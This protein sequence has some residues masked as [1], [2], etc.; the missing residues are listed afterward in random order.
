MFYRNHVFAAEH[1]AFLQDSI[2]PGRAWQEIFPKFYEFF[3]KATAT[4]DFWALTLY[5]KDSGSY[6][7]STI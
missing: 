2:I 6:R 7:I 5:N 1:T 4:I 3:Q